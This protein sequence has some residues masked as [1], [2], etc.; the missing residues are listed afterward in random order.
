GARPSEQEFVVKYKVAGV[1]SDDAVLSHGG[2]SGGYFPLILQAPEKVREEALVRRQLIF[3]LDT[4]GSMWGFPI[5]MAK[6]T[7]ARALDNLRKDETF[8][9]ITFSGDTRVLFPEP[10]PATPENVAK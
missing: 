2:K 1:G 10:A 3:V 7:I 4:S 9:L 6:K 5:E 8:N